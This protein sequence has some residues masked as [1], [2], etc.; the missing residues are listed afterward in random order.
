MTHHVLPAPPHD[1]LRVRAAIRRRR[2]TGGKWSR[3][4]TLLFVLLSCSAAWTGIGWL[5]FR[6]IAG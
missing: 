2:M 4:A 6:L 1:I 5:V 3:R